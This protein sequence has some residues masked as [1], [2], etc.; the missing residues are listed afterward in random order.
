VDE[1]HLVLYPLTVGGGK[2][3]FSNGTHA[4]FDLISAKSYPTG[5]VGLHY[6]RKRS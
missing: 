6:A 1:L 4:T 3:L 2:R 5:V